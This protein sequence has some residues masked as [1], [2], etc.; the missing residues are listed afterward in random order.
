VRPTR[1]PFLLV[2]EDPDECL[3]E[4]ISA[5]RLGG[6]RHA[7]HVLCFVALSYVLLLWLT[8]IDRPDTAFP[9]LWCAGIV[10]AHAE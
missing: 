2:A 8:T 9:Q 10:G 4:E 7:L 6:L 5:E 1:L 3:V